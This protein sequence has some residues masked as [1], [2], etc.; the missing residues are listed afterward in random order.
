MT[1]EDVKALCHCRDPANSSNGKVSLWL[2]PTSYDRPEFR[3]AWHRLGSEEQPS[4]E[5]FE[6]ALEA[7]LR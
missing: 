5:T 6:G 1:L 2:Q 4:V 7:K 3:E